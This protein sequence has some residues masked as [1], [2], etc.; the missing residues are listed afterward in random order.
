MMASDDERD[1]VQT[2]FPEGRPQLVSLSE[3]DVRGM[4]LVIQVDRTVKADLKGGANL[5]IPHSG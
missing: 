1:Y 4:E 2:V 5:H 3:A